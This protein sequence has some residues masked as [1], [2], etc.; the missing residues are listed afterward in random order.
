MSVNML[1]SPTSTMMTGLVVP[2]LFKS[3]DPPL[4]KRTGHETHDKIATITGATLGLHAKQL[5]S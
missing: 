2:P 1:T 3:L 5:S 4:V